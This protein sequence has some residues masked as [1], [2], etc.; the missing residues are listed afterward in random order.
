MPDSTTVEDCYPIAEK[1]GMLKQFPTSV[2][3]L[4][5]AT[6]WRRLPNLTTWPSTVRAGGRC[7]RTLRCWNRRKQRRNVTASLW[8]RQLLRRLGLC[9]RG[10]LSARTF[11]QVAARRVALCA[12]R[13]RSYR[14]GGEGRR[15]GR[16]RSLRSIARK[17]FGRSN[18]SAQR[19]DRRHRRQQRRCRSGRRRHHAATRE[20]SRLG[21]RWPI[22]RVST[23]I[24]CSSRLAMRL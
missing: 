22:S 23:L 4:F 10:G 3:E 16:N 11:A 18:H 7:C 19:R 13:R 21:S 12:L 9:S 14:E 17:K 6:P 5:H 8:N 15:G 20:I 1:Y 24:L 2:R